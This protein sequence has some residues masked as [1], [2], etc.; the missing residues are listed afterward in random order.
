[1]REHIEFM[2]KVQ[3]RVDKGIVYFLTDYINS[4]FSF[5]IGVPR[6]YLDVFDSIK[7]RISVFYIR[8]HMELVYILQN[9]V[10]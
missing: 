2:Y 8:E 10:E 5:N 1:M 3:N 9:T 4:N 7:Y 6:L